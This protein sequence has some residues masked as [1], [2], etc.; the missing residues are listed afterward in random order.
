[1]EGGGGDG[2]SSSSTIFRDKMYSSLA[3]ANSNA[4]DAWLELTLKIRSANLDQRKI[5]RE[6]AKIRLLTELE[7]IGQGG[8]D[9]D[10]GTGE[11]A[12][13]FKQVL[14]EEPVQG[15]AGSGRR[16]EVFVQEVMLAGPRN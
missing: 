6:T 10:N 14:V 3:L 1:M 16:V 7:R 13:Y 4:V 2:E 5:E 8:D 15:E 9:Y 12:R 11:G